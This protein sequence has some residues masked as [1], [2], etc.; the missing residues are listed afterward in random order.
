M[1]AERRN[2]PAVI[3]APKKAPVVREAIVVP[4]GSPRCGA[5][6]AAV[7]TAWKRITSRRPCSKT[8]TALSLL[9]LE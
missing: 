3:D 8:G 6:R 7:I 9:P 1:S 2:L 4:A 5:H